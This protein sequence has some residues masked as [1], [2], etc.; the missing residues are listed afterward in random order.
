[1]DGARGPAVRRVLRGVR[2]ERVDA[3][4]VHIDRRLERAGDRSRAV[5]EAA[6]GH[7]AVADVRRIR[8]GGGPRAR[9]GRDPVPRLR[10]GSPFDFGNVP[11]PVPAALGTGV[12]VHGTGV[13]TAFHITTDMP[14]VAYQ[15]L[16]YGGGAAA[17]TG[18]SLLIPTSAWQ[19]NY[20]AVSAYDRA[21]PRRRSTI[22]AGPV[23]R[24]R[25]A[26]RQHDGHDAAE[27]A[28][29]RRA[30]ACRRAPR[31]RRGR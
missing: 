6:A 29:S 28:R 25:R 7:R 9:Q 17:A 30:A 10:H 16:P 3:A 5:R 13:G 22:P 24:H 4:P 23:A 8:S 11:C 14:V 31:T 26:G 19:T 1:M 27:V 15:M 12:Q 18:A 2:R 20:V 21:A